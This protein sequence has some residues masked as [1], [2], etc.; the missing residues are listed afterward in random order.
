MQSIEIY[1]PR[2]AANGRFVGLNHEAVLYDADALVQPIRIVRNLEKV[3]GFEQGAPQDFVK[4]VPAQFPVKGVATPA[5]PGDTVQFELPDM[6]GRPWAKLWE[7][8]F[9]R[10]MQKPKGADLFDF[11]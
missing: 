4:C 10:D 3:S 11:R 5:T 8:H 7:E 2:R 6:Y 9:E 1:T